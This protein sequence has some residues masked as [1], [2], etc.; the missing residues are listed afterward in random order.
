MS[1][2]ILITGVSSGFGYLTAKSLLNEGHNVAGT[3]R[4]TKG[5]NENVAEELQSLGV[6]LIEMDVTDDA[7]VESGVKRSIEML[8]GLDVVINNAGL[9]VIGMQEH[10]TSDDMKYVFDVNVFGVQ[11][12]M[13][14]AL[15]YLRKQGHGLVIYVSSL[16]GRMTLPFYGVYNSSKWALEGLA[17]NY[18]TE[19]SGFGIESSIIEPGGFPTEFAGNLMQPSDN[20]RDSEYGDFMNA[21][22]AMGEAFGKALEANTEQRPQKV[23]DAIVEIINMPYGEKPMRKVVDYM[24]MGAH[25]EPYNEHLDKLTIGIYSNFG[26]ESML[27]VKK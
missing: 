13:R 9:G 14:A 18:R 26:N 25:I 1:K 8:G 22:L 10:F 21:P 11:R 2:N 15:P 20:S 7:Q 23:A 4:S 16:L 24:G 27:K 17:E 3:M 19:L 12:V 6:K 5:K